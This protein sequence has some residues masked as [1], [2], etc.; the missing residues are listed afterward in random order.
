MSPIG[1]VWWNSWGMKIRRVE[2]LPRILSVI[3]W[4][5]RT[6][7]LHKWRHTYATNMLRSNIDI[8]SLQI[9]LGH[10][11]LATTEKYLRSLGVLDLRNKIEKSNIANWIK[12]RR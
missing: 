8:K 1:F 2:T 7:T 3:S 10:K 5:M 9:L 12:T 11:N 4:A 6:W